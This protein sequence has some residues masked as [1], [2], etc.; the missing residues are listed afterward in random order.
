MK[1]SRK[2]VYERFMRDEKITALKSV[3]ITLE[4]NER[5]VIDWIDH[6]LQRV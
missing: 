1:R 6:Q 2:T 4:D 3:Y 5:N